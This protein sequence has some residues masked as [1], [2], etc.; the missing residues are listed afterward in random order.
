M[1]NT[2]LA[3]GETLRVV[4]YAGTGKTH[5]LRAY[6]QEHSDLVILYVAVGATLR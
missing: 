3:V 1:V 2:D 4:A 5:T 6:A